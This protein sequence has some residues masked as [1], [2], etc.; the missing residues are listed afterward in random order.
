MGVRRVRRWAPAL[1]PLDANLH[2]GLLHSQ[3]KLISSPYRLRIVADSLDKC[4]KSLDDACGP[5]PYSYVGDGEVQIRSKK[6]Y[7]GYAICHN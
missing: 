2:Q 3:A 7:K 5:S 6:V 4:G 1:S